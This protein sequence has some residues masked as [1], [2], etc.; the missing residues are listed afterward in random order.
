MLKIASGSV[1]DIF[2]DDAGDLH[3]LFTDRVS[4]FDYGPIPESIPGRGE[5]LARFAKMVFQELKVP[6]LFLGDSPL[7]N[8]AIKMKKARHPKFNLDS[9]ELVFIPLEVIFRLG[10]PE[11]SSFAQARF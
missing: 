3:F 1:K 5:H 6:S 4:V 7:G 8:A 10:V 11:G 9:P 2:E